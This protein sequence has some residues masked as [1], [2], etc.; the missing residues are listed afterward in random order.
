MADPKF[1][2]RST[3]QSLKI[4]ADHVGAELHGDSGELIIQ[5]VAPLD[6]AGEQ[7]ISFLDN[8]KYKK[9]FSKTKASACIVSQK[10]IEHAPKGCAL[11]VSNNPYKAY[12]L[13]AQLFYPDTL[14]KAQISKKAHIHQTAHIAQGCVIEAGVYIG[15]N[16]NLGQGCWV[17]ANT[18]IADHVEIGAH[19]RIGA[20]ATITHA[21]IGEAVRIYS[22]VRI[23]QD[24]F[25]FAIDPAGHVKV[26]QLGRVIIGDNVEV[27]AN[28]CIDRGAGP[29]TLI[30]NGTWIDNLVQ[31]GHNAKIGRGCV[32][33]AQVGIAGST[34]IEDYVVVAAQAG[35]AGHLTIGTGSRI[36]AQS[37]IMQDLKPGSEVLGSPAVPIRERLKHVAYLKKVTRKN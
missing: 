13:I 26:P 35:I 9:D 1:H 19:C 27:G 28:S 22:G 11:L 7:D 18:V 21:I 12:A 29:D 15:E 25:G 24:G 3:P 2:K 4:L 33:V 34:V 17:G 32:I 37:G 31:I 20:N 6:Q 8:I 14:P 5:D 30:G 16:V 23:G 10:M 36:G